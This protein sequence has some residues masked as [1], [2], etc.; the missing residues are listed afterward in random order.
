MLSRYNNLYITIYSKK[1]GMFSMKS[2]NVL[3]LLIKDWKG[4]YKWLILSL[5]LVV[6][7]VT[8]TLLIPYFSSF[9]I[10]NGI[11]VGNSDVIVKYGSYMLITAI[12]VGICEFLN[13]A[14]AVSFSERTCHGLRSGAFSHVQS[15]SFGTLDKFSASDLLVRL[16]TDVQNIKIGIIQGLSNLFRIPLLLLVALFFLWITAPQLM[17]VTLVLVVAESLLLVAYIWLSSKAYDVK[18]IKYDRLN[19]VLRESMVG[20]RVVKA[21]VNKILKINVFKKHRKSF[22]SH[23]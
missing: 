9:L 17:W 8:G 11:L 13:L 4:S 3:K 15:F 14:I 5:F 1:W 19:N 22:M 12:F 16:T 7:V 21:F 2:Q 6:T 23:P 20:I 18:Q 10:N